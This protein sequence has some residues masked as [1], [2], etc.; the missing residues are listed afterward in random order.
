M[1]ETTAIEWTDASWNP[2]RA[3][4]WH[5]GRGT[6]GWHCEHVS[7]GCRNCYAETM[8]KRL[9]TGLDYKPGNLEPRGPVTPFLDE[10]LLLAQI[11]RASCRERVS[12]PV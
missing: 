5:L 1:G 8:N 12:S 6:F 11:G 3:R 2:L 7:E 4:R 10:K 9:G